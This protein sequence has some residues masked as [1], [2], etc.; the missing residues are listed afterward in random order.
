MEALRRRARSDL[1]APPP[2][3]EE[4]RKLSLPRLRLAKLQQDVSEYMPST[5][6]RHADTGAKGS[7]PDP[8]PRGALTERRVS[9]LESGRI[10]SRPSGGA[11]TERTPDSSQPLKKK[12][13]S[14]RL[15]QLARPSRRDFLPRP[16]TAGRRML[17]GQEDERMTRYLHPMQ[18][19]PKA[20]DKERSPGERVGHGGLVTHPARQQLKGDIFTPLL[21]MAA[22]SMHVSTQLMAAPA[23]AALAGVAS[24]RT[25]M[26]SFGAVDIMLQLARDGRKVAARRG[27]W[28]TLHELVLSSDAAARFVEIGG[29]DSLS[30]ALPLSPSLSLSLPLSPSLPSFLPLPPSPHSSTHPPKAG[31][32][33]SAACG[34]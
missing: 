11:L 7:E 30:S 17:P 27:A 34:A 14:S 16:P 15:T 1:L 22:N 6:T 5:S 18:R 9:F 29:V 33:A 13:C 25:V 19:K 26:S 2:K 8:F 12:T 31:V 10:F 4:T 23:M 3:A 24:N 32:R 28:D 20:Q 21:D